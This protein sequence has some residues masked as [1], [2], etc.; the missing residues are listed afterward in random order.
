MSKQIT[1][2][3]EELARDILSIYIQSQYIFG[4]VWHEQ[5]LMFGKDLTYRKT[6][7]QILERLCK[8]HGLINI[9]ITGNKL[10]LILTPND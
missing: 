2:I 9:S 7:A 3:Y 10:T 5:C 6:D 8:E 1:E 4:L